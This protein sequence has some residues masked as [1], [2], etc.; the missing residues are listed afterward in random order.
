MSRPPRWPPGAR[1]RRPGPPPRARRGAGASRREHEQPGAVPGREPERGQ[2]LVQGGQGFR[3]AAPSAGGRAARDQGEHGQERR[4]GRRRAEVV[5]VQDQPLRAGQD[6]AAAAGGRAA[7]RLLQ[8][9]RAPAAS[10]SSGW[11]RTRPRRAGG[12][13]TRTPWPR[14]TSSSSAWST[15]RRRWPSGMSTW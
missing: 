2:C 3:G 8:D 9:H 6:W 10:F 4:R 14:T 12:R 15:R 11:P 1:W 7:A 5:P 13:S